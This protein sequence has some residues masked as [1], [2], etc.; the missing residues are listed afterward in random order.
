M[1]GTRGYVYMFGSFV[2]VCAGKI[3]L[4]FSIGSWALQCST[5]SIQAGICIAKHETVTLCSL[6]F[7]VQFR[8]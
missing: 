7:V 3:L 1:V 2:L 6:G 4:V 8:V 5:L